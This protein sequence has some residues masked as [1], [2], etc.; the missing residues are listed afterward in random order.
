MCRL[1]NET[2]DPAAEAILA[3]GVARGEEQDLHADG[4]VGWQVDDEIDDPFHVEVSLQYEETGTSEEAPM[5]DGWLASE[6]A[7]GGRLS[8]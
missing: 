8:E 4:S 6:T 2:R 5:L 1:G 7:T 3:N